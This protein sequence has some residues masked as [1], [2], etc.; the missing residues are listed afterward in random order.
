MLKLQ[1]YHLNVI[2]KRGRELCVSRAHLPTTYT[3]E[4]IE[5]YDVLSDALPN[6]SSNTVIRQ[7]K[8]HFAVHGIPQQLMTD[9]ATSFSSR[10]FKN[11]AHLWDFQHVASSPNYPRSNG[12]AERGVRSAKHL[13]EK[14]ARDGSDVYAALLNLRNTPRDGLPSPAQCLLSRRTRS[15]IPLVPSQ[16][17]PRVES[18]VQAALFALRQKGK[19]SHDKSAR[20]LSPLEPGQT[21][22]ME[23]TCGFDKLAT[24][25]GKALQP[26][27]YVVQSN[28]KA[29]V[30]NRRHLLQVPESYCP[31]ITMSVPMI[32]PEP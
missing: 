9:N 10:E 3:P 2:Y 8:R 4:A 28:G 12:L 16:L 6:L 5:D 20:C 23:T 24:V 30:R 1:R 15:L 18:N 21:V 14:C 25:S 31:T 7:L 11:F 32:F 27:S 29:Y 26:N 19:R 13:L 17:T 22:R